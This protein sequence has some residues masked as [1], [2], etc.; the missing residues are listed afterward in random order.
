MV[1][2]IFDFFLFKSSI[3]NILYFKDDKKKKFFFLLGGLV[4]KIEVYIFDFKR[5]EVKMS[6]Y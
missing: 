6:Y 5:V 4:K 1:S 2:W 3:L